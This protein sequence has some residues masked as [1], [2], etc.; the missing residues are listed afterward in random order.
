MYA[1]LSVFSMPR[2]TSF[3]EVGVGNGFG[4]AVAVGSG[5]EVLVGAGVFVAVGSGVGV[6]GGGGAGVAVGPGPAV[7]VD[8]PATTGSTSVSPGSSFIEPQADAAATNTNRAKMTVRFIIVLRFFATKRL[9]VIPAPTPFVV[10]AKALTAGLQ[11]GQARRFVFS[12]CCDILLLD[13][14]RRHSTDRPTQPINWSQPG[15]AGS[16]DPEVGV[17]GDFPQVAFRVGEVAGV[18]APERIFGRFH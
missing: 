12:T 4:V 7:G 8:K 13:C 6:R 5:T 11:I 2:V 18:P 17:P 16:L 14:G 15:T 3:R 9:T 1:M 10:A